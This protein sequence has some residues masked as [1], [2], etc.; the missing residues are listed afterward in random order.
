MY[1][2]LNKRYSVLFTRRSKQKQMRRRLKVRTKHKRKYYGLGGCGA[3]F[4]NT[5][6]KNSVTERAAVHVAR[7]FMSE[8]S[9]TLL[10]H[11]RQ[12]HPQETCIHYY[13]GPA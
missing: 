9:A 11:E 3:V 13:Y 1:A 12:A 6:T 8:S 4:L 10:H 7:V 2:D 5:T